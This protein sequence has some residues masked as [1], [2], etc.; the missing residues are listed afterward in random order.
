MLYW[1]MDRSRL[2]I[3]RRSMALLLLVGLISSNPSLSYL[4][5]AR[6]IGV[7]GQPFLVIR[8]LIMLLNYLVWYILC[9]PG[10]LVMSDSF[11]L[12]LSIGESSSRSASG[13]AMA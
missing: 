6:I 3:S 5:G 8:L 4:S 13:N 7:C 12:A 2:S 9:G 1:V 10:L 11:D